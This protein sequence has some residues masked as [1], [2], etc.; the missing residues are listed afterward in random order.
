MESQRWKRLMEMNLEGV[1]PYKYLEVRA[2]CSWWTEM[3]LMDCDSMEISR[4]LVIQLSEMEET[5][6]PCTSYLIQSGENCF[7]NML[8]S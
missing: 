7:E 4:L 3:I 1:S 5:W 8:L 6:N 2:F